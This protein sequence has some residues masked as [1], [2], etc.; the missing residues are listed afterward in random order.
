M[1]W[2]YAGAC[3]L[4]DVDQRQQVGQDGLGTHI[5]VG[6]VG[7]EPVEASTGLEVNE[8]DSEVV[9]AEKPIEGALGA[10]WP[11]W[12]SIRALRGKAGGNC[13]G[14]I[15]RL[16]IELCRACR[17]YLSQPAGSSRRSSF[18]LP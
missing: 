2:N 10:C 1:A 13:R 17:S 9:G 11:L 18:A 4:A 16:L 3:E 12:A 14:R 8:R 15:Y 5:L 7:V 6:S